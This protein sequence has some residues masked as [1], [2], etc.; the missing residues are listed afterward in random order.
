MYILSPLAIAFIQITTAMMVIGHWF[1]F[2]PW[3]VELFQI[4]ERDFG[5]MLMV[6]G[7]GSI[8]SMLVTN[9]FLL[10]KFGPNILMP[11]GGL[12]FAVFLYIW[13][14]VDSVGV[15]VAMIFPVS[16]AFGMINPS[17]LAVTV[18]TEGE[19]GR[20]LTPLFLA[21]F[22]AGTMIGTVG[23]GLY[24]A[25]NLPPE[26]LFLGL[27]VLSI[28]LTCLTFFFSDTRV[29]H[30]TPDPFR[31]R[32][33]ARSTLI[34]GAIAAIP[35]STIGII[36]DWS[37]L[38]LTRDLGLVLAYGGAGIFAFT[39]MEIV[40]RLTGEKMINRWGEKANGTYAMWVGCT[41]MIA[42]IY[43][44]NLIAILFGFGALGLFSAN[45]YALLLNVA[46]R[47]NPSNAAGVVNDVNIIAFSGF[48][49]GP[50]IVGFVAE[51]ISIAAC[52]YLL[53]IAWAMS[54]A[55]ML[56]RFNAIHKP[57]S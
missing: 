37:A 27:M 56:S 25:T 53:A 52:M 12:A 38:W 41:I 40:G 39:A 3:K 19:T 1:V 16:L 13:L 10:P 15:F 11:L 51:Y 33:P 14:T 21:C 46:G 30:G 24:A 5:L 57:A 22:S 23:G 55:I 34:L 43:S 32:M 44:G 48:L 9:K 4:A 54:A 29:Q 6:F 35:L 36:M 2:I 17:A 18:R 45:H 31:M 50:T 49:F 47:T 8:I 20:R 26:H 7:I 28:A 42:A